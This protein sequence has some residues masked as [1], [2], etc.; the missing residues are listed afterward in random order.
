[1][2]RVGAGGKTHTPQC[3]RYARART[4]ARQYPLRFIGRRNPE[5]DSRSR[6]V[7]PLLRFVICH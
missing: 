2:K 5:G 1:M 3:L 6:H 7:R 4:E